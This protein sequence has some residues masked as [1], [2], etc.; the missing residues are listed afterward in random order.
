MGRGSPLW[1]QQLS[2][3][4]WVSRW[5]QVQGPAWEWSHAFPKAPEWLLPAHLTD[6]KECHQLRGF[7]SPPACCPEPEGLRPRTQALTQLA[8]APPAQPTAPTGSAGSPADWAPLPSG[9]PCTLLAFATWHLCM[10]SRLMF[11]TPHSGHHAASADRTLIQRKVG[12]LALPV[13]GPSMASTAGESVY[14]L[15]FSWCCVPSTRPSR[16]DAQ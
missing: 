12:A 4:P 1:G 5:I 14:P 9:C 7:R 13:L 16:A 6:G 3:G 8:P 15:G 11:L 10:Q 2:P